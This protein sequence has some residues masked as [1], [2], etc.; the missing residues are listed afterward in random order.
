MIENYQQRK[1][2][3]VTTK[4]GNIATVSAVYS[5]GIALILPGDTAASDKHYPFNAAVQFVAGQRVHIARESGT[6]IVEYPIGGDRAEPE[7]GRVIH[8][9]GNDLFAADGSA[10]QKLYG[11]L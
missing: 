9:Q 1:A 11:R 3:E 10:S 7:P 5:D 2:L 6:I 8:E 4:S